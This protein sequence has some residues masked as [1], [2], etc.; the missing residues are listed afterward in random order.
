MRSRWRDIGNSPAGS[1]R[2]P[3]LRTPSRSITR[4][5]G[6]VGA[7][8]EKQL[9]VRQNRQVR[10]VRNIDVWVV[11]AKS[12][13]MGNSHNHTFPAPECFH[14]SIKPRQILQGDTPA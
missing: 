10:R 6:T 4:D 13:E 14:R 7:A 2:W 3:L 8:Q 11:A 9:R 12:L 1:S 5:W